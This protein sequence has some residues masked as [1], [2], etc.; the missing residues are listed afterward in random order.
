MNS[1]GFYETVLRELGVP[2]YLLKDTNTTIKQLLDYTGGR[3]AM[4]R[5]SKIN[6]STKLKEYLEKRLKPKLPL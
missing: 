5:L 1:P 3:F 6:E 4:V 2:D